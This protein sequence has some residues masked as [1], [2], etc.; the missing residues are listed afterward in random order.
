MQ[1][2]T[3]TRIPIPPGKKSPLCHFVILSNHSGALRSCVYMI[4]QF[5][6]LKVD[7][8]I[9]FQ[10]MI[11]SRKTF[12]FY[13]LYYQTSLFWD[14]FGMVNQPLLLN[15]LASLS[16]FWM[17]I[18]GFVSIFSS[19]SVEIFWEMYHLHPSSLFY[20][21]VKE[22][23]CQGWQRKKVQD[24]NI[25]DFGV[26]KIPEFQPSILGP[27]SFWAKACHRTAFFFGGLGFF[28]KLIPPL[29]PNK[30]PKLQ[31]GCWLL[32]FGC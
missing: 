18:T 5:N 13:I 15:T 25:T 3:D 1:M 22:K 32:P 21:I 16:Q 26:P 27:Q 12:F 7:V 23:G 6:P 14:C 28:M 17:A 19:A 30:C 8:R 29:E 2:Y 20:D 31:L 10:D 9:L 11:S 24:T 4:S